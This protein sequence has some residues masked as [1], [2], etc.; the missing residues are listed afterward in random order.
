[1]ESWMSKWADTL[2]KKHIFY[3]GGSIGAP[4]TSILHFL[5]VLGA[6]KYPHLKWKSHILLVM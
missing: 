5:G 3:F 2:F 6:P 4:Q 1:M